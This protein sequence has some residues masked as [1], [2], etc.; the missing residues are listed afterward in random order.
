MLKLTHFLK[1]YLV[2]S[3]NIVLIEESK[4]QKSPELNPELFVKIFYLNGLW[5]ADEIMI[6]SE[7]YGTNVVNWI[8]FYQKTHDGRLFY[9]HQ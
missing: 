4:N 5:L 8:F 7:N 9:H 6:L 3:I 1:K 2:S